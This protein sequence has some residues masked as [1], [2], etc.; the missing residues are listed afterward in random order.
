MNDGIYHPFSEERFKSYQAGIRSLIQKVKKSGARLILLTP[1]PFDPLPMKK[2]NKLVGKDS[3]KFAW[4]L[5]YE[6]Y[7]SVLKKYADWILGQGPAVDM[8]VDIR[9]P[10]IDFQNEKRMKDADFVM[11][12]DGVHFNST[13]H[14]IIATS[15]FSKLLPGQK[16]VLNPEVAKSCHARMLILRDAWLSETGHK[17]PGVKKGLPLDEATRKVKEHQERIRELTAK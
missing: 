14:R 1:P 8:V 3:S 17:R 4:F 15:L 16:P 2:K 7:D 13:C 5:I 10:I 9:R 11:S 6:D 12:G